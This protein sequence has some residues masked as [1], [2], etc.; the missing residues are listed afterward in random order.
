[1]VV[2]SMHNT[3]YKRL[4]SYHGCVEVATITS[5]VFLLRSALF[6]T[7]G[8][9]DM[10]DEFLLG[11]VLVHWPRGVMHFIVVKPVHGHLGTK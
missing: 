2:P 9:L 1:M 11:L 4:R 6:R 3:F 10:D 8:F 5:D 7:G